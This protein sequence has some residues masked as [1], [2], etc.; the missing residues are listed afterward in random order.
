[1]ST[2]LMRRWKKSMVETH[3]RFVMDIGPQLERAHWGSSNATTKGSILTLREVVG[4]AKV[5][6]RKVSQINYCEVSISCL[7]LIN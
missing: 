4:G 6:T 1:M 2:L 5:T 7:Y 3:H